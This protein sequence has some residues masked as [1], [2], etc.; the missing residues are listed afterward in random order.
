M[1]GLYAGNNRITAA[2]R[3]VALAAYNAAKA[4]LDI[5][6]PS[7]KFRW[8]A[9]MS[10]TGFEQGLTARAAGLRASVTALTGSLTGSGQRSAAIAAAGIDYQKLGAAVA[11][12]MDERG[13]G[14]TALYV[15]GQKLGETRVADGVGRRLRRRSNAGVKGRSA[16][17]VIA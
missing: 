15:D 5:N 1:A 12:A 8:L 13:L 4:A 2:A 14:D 9:E 6:S 17:L 16:Q 3:T 10:A 11:D 7:G